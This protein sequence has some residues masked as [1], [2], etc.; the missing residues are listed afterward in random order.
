MALRNDGGRF[1]RGFVRLF[2]RTMAGM[3]YRVICIWFT[4][5]EGSYSML[6]ERVYI[7]RNCDIRSMHQSETS[8]PHDQ[9][10]ADNGRNVRVA[11][12]GGREA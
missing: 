5:V 12:R 11:R 4:R 1:A 10:G 7:S 2:L 6:K 8:P 9:K 3:R